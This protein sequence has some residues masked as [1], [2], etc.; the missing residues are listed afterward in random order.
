[1]NQ[2]PPPGWYQDHSGTGLRYW[3]GQK[4]TEHTAPGGD[5]GGS[6]AQR[7]EVAGAT[8]QAGTSHAADPD[9]AKKNWFVRHKVL[10]GLIAAFLLLTFIGALS[11]EDEDTTPAAA[12]TGT[13]AVDVAE[14]DPTPATEDEP[15][16]EP[17]DSDGD[18]VTDDEDYA[19]DDPKVQTA[20]DVDT[21]KDGVPDYK[22]AFPKNAKYSKDSDEDG[23]ADQLDA[24][25]D[26][27][28]YSKDSDG[29]GVADEK[30]AF[31]KDPS[32]SKITLA[33]SNALAAAKD[34]L[35]FQAFSRQ[36]LIDQLS[37]DYGSGFK[38]ADAT[39]AVDQLDTDWNKQAVRAA[40]SYLDFQPFS[41]QGL[42]DQLSSAYG[43]QFT[44]A[45]ATYAVNKIGL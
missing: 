14:S 1:M 3:D 18:G 15:D 41:R 35:Q 26:D 2:T 27:A 44:V 4:W 12:E 42:I 13:S 24:F 20:D 36:G 16:V 45:Q 8:A 7:P 32:R 19:P 25:P 34:Y 31:P 6:T 30:D 5:A 28:R 39:W 10:S 9:P 33:M 29:D 17:V 43:S 23:V 38:L 21:D 22:D 40:K 37:S 11:G